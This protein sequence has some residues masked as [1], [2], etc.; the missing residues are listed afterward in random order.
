LR[1][2]FSA[3]TKPV[4]VTL[5]MS[6]HAVASG[7]GRLK[8]YIPGIQ[9]STPNELSVPQRMVTRALRFMTARA[10][11]RWYQRRNLVGELEAAKCWLRS[12]GRAF[13]FFYGE[14]SYRYLGALKAFGSRNAIVCTYHVPPDKFA[15]T[16]TTQTHLM[17]VDAIIVVAR[18]QIDTFA[19]I[20]GANRVFFVPHGVDVD[21][22]KP[23]EREAGGRREFKC[24]FVGTHLRDFDTLAAAAR[25]LASR[26]DLRFVVVTRPQNFVKFGGLP[27]VECLAGISDEFLLGLFQDSDLLVFPLLDCTANNTLLEAMACGLPAVTTDLPGVRDYVSRDSAILVPK[28]NSERLAEAIVSLTSSRDRLAAMAV[29]SR[30]RALELRW[31]NVARQTCEIYEWA[32][33]HVQRGN[34]RP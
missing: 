12:R 34:R 14:N 2:D 16:T 30:Q 26:S 13:H 5:R 6:G 18:T 32:A 28:G 27:N 1:A 29:A 20:V 21:Y 8:D 3:D 11:S 31:E 15:E 23:T 7:Y 25:L 19:P 33:R 24:L 10:K 22:F 17:R 4:L 9:I